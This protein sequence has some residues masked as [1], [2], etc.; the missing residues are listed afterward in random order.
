MLVGGD[1]NGRDLKLAVFLW[2]VFEGLYMCDYL[3]AVL[4]ESNCNCSENSD[5]CDV[6]QV[7]ILHWNLSRRSSDPGQMFQ[8]S[9]ELNEINRSITVL[10]EL[11][12]HHIKA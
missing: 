2:G 1:E 3:L 9:N 5:G 4:P 10:I 8:A 11:F 6:G 7:V 12:T